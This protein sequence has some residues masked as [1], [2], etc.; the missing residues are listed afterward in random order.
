MNAYYNFKTKEYEYRNTPD[1][2]EDYIP[3]DE[4]AQ[5]LYQCHKMLGKSNIEAAKETLLAV[6]GLKDKESL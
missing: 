6:T 4:A 2:W 3:Q 5:G 1:D